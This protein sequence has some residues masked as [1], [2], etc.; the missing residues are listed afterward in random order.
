MFPQQ[1][2]SERLDGMPNGKPVKG[3]K[4]ISIWNSLF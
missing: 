4:I 1:V 3:V 2:V